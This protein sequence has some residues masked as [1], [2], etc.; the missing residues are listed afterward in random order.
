MREFNN[1]ERLVVGGLI[2]AAA[3]GATLGILF[4]PHKGKKTRQT[5][6][7]SV[8]KTANR[9]NQELKQDVNYLK[10]KLGGE[11]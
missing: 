5:I 1:R 3:V 2:I 9:F 4:A 11:R 10:D 7:D 6:A 8:K